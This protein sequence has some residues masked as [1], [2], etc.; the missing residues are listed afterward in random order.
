MADDS[1]LIEI[2]HRTVEELV[3]DGT[4][5]TIRI[6]RTAVKPQWASLK[7]AISSRVRRRH[8]SARPTR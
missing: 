5:E 4:S 2:I 7:V 8:D 1:Q 3:A 6:R